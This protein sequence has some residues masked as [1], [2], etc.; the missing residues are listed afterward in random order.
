M[1]RAVRSPVFTRD[2]L[3]DKMIVP[4]WLW[5]LGVQMGQN[6]RFVG[7]PTVRITPGARIQIADEVAIYSREASNPRG[8]P[9]RTILAALTSHSE[10]KIGSHTGISGVSIVCRD[11]IHIGEWVQIGPGTCIWD[12]DGHPIDPVQR[13]ERPTRDFRSAPITIGNDVLI[14]ARAM[15]LKGVTIGDRAVIGA[16]AIVT[17]DVKP[18]HIV[19]GNPARVIGSITELEKLPTLAAQTIQALSG[20]IIS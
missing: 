6:C 13:R 5:M 12:N 15:I 3:V 14:G 1:V 11:Q 7:L 16:G 17:K 18:G 8:L 4:L 10:I 2:A 19:A 20:E 9:T